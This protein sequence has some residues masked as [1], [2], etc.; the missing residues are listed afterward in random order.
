MQETWGVLTACSAE[1]IV[2]PD[3]DAIGALSAMNRAGNSRLMVVAE[4]RSQQ[5]KHV[6]HDPPALV[7]QEV[8]RRWS[9]ACELLP[10]HLPL[11]AN[12]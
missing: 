12:Y 6:P 4:R 11:L 2:S 10:I 7:V 1:T 5:V 9:H 8:V 3:T